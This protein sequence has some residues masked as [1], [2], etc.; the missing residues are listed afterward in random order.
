MSDRCLVVATIAVLG[1]TAALAAQ[2]GVSRL[3]PLDTK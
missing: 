1:C 3:Q 2:F